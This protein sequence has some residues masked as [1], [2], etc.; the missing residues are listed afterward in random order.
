MLWAVGI[1][2]GFW[3]IFYS[4]PVIGWL[5]VPFV[6]LRKRVHLESREDDLEA[7]V[8]EATQWNAEHPDDPVIIDVHGRLTPSIKASP[9]NRLDD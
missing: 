1:W 2:L 9:E 4:L 3:A 5:L 8:A 7:R 6:W